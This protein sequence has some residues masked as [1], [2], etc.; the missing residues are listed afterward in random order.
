[1]NIAQRPVMDENLYAR[2]RGRV[3]LSWQQ[4]CLGGILLLAAVLNLALLDPG[5]YTNEYYAAAVRS[6]LGSWHNFFFN[7]FDPGGF[8]SIDKPPVALWLETASAWLFGY[9]GISLILPSAL[10]GV[11]SVALLYV[12]VKRVFGPLAALIAAFVLAITPIA[13]VMSRHN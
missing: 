10:A 2:I 9:N 6:M 1:M 4:I 8:I 13:V 12:T 5:Y 3:S 11:G 7:S